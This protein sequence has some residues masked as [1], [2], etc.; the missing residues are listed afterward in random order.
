M[1]LGALFTWVWI[2]E[3]QTGPDPN[4]VP[5]LF[6]WPK[7]PSKGLETFA[8]GRAYAI[9]PDTTIDAQTGLPRG[10]NQRLRFAEKIPD[11]WDLIFSKVKKHGFST[12]N[13]RLQSDEDLELDETRGPSGPAN[14]GPANPL[15]RPA[16]TH[17]APG[18]SLN[19]PVS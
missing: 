6:A 15:E 3:L 16:A 11:L 9:N 10:E 13:N 18:D 17:D 2:P 5:A 7:Y 19:S 14:I 4:Y 1:L 12:K 8:R